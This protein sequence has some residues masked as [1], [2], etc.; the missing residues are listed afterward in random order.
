MA[1][2]A[3]ARDSESESASCRS[4]SYDDAR[5]RLPT[6][7]WSGSAGVVRGT[8]SRS[9]CSHRWRCEKDGST[10]TTLRD[11]STKHICTEPADGMNVAGWGT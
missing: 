2:A 5:E 6:K 4:S 1:I 7:L 8:S 10:T 11:D 9:A 3:S